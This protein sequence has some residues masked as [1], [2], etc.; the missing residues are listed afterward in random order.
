[1]YRGSAANF[2]VV[3]CTPTAAVA[4]GTAAGPPLLSLTSPPRSRFCAGDNLLYAA[5]GRY[6]RK[7]IFRIS[8]EIYEFPASLGVYR[9]MIILKTPITLKS[10]RAAN[11]SKFQF[12]NLR[13]SKCFRST[14]LCLPWAGSRAPEYAVPTS[15]L[16]LDP[17]LAHRQAMSNS[18][19]RRGSAALPSYMG[20][21]R[22]RHNPADQGSLVKA[23]PAAV[24]LAAAFVTG[25]AHTRQAPK[26]SASV[27]GARRLDWEHHMDDLENRKA[28]LRYYRMPEET[29]DKL[30]RLLAPHLE[31]NAHIARECVVCTVV[32]VLSTAVPQFLSMC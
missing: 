32:H 11:T 27:N 2:S 13:I 16:L 6:K 1:M 17:S 14:S 18:R 31:K 21:A 9:G 25:V 29:F 19:E 5:K 23:I 24:V 3:F 12:R 20:Y 10:N 4:V 22:P 28:F 15:R 26:A 30:V 8:F 7:P